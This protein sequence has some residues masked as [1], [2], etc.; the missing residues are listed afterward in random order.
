MLVLL[1][2]RQSG[3]RETGVSRSC[4]GLTREVEKERKSRL[5]ENR[6]SVCGLP[7]RG[8]ASV[9]EPGA[10]GWIRSWFRS[11]RPTLSTRLVDSADGLPRCY[12]M[13]WVGFCSSPYQFRSSTLLRLKPI[14]AVGY[15]PCG[16]KDRNSGGA[17]PPERKHEI[18]QQPE[19]HEDHPEYLFLH[20][21]DFN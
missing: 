13:Q 3:T 1:E 20:R 5:G 12:L 19:Q 11:P 6:L 8:C 7:K 16:E 9:P 15:P 14:T 21:S 2:L 4:R 17:G 18:G 10:V